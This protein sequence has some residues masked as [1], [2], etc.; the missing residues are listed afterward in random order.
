MKEE[1][2]RKM[3]YAAYA[4]IHQRGWK[5]SGFHHTLGQVKRDFPGNQVSNV[6]ENENDRTY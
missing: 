5:S 3:C 1:V 6:A 2:G 4:E